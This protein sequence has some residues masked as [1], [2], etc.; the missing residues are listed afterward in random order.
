MSGLL[1]CSSVDEAPGGGRVEHPVEPRPSLSAPLVATGSSSPLPSSSNSAPPSAPPSVS[2]PGRQLTPSEIYEE[3]TGIQLSPADK[4]IMDDCP[5]HAL[6]K[7]VPKRACTKDEQCGDG[8]CDRGRCG[9][10]WTCTVEYGQRCENDEK[11]GVHY[12]CMDGRCR[13]CVSDGECKS[14]LNNGNPKCRP[15]PFDVPTARI[16]WGSVPSILGSSAPG[17]LPK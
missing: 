1:S 12:L 2:P 17:P 5:S 9:A 11:C 13:S 14:T 10:I 8:F 3:S 16:C 15:D 6:S 7:K 4:T